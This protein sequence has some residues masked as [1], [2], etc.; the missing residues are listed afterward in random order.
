MLFEKSWVFLGLTI[1]VKT[2]QTMLWIWMIIF[3]ITSHM[4]LQ[5]MRDDGITPWRGPQ[6]KHP[7]LLQ[8]LIDIF[9]KIEDI[10]ADLVALNV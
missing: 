6:V 5:L 10:V 1:L 7:L 2:I 8:V 4:L 3:Y 9:S